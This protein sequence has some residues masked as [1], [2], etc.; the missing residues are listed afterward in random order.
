MTFRPTRVVNKERADLRDN[1]V[2]LAMFGGP[3]LN[4]FGPPET[5]P[6]VL[7][8]YGNMVVAADQVFLARIKRPV[9]GVD[10]PVK[11]IITGVGTGAAATTGGFGIYE[12][13]Y[14]QDNKARLYLLTSSTVHVAAGSIPQPSSLPEAYMLKR[15]KEYVLGIL[16]TASTY[17]GSVYHAADPLLVAGFGTSA[18]YVAASDFPPVINL[19]PLDYTGG[20][21]RV[22]AEP[23]GRTIMGYLIAPGKSPVLIY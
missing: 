9:R 5:V 2:E 8:T 15:N 21:P 10:Y 12:I 23:D 13:R 7:C 19:T 20:Y 6:D 11:A 18:S 17:A 4:T 3:D 22:Q 14:D 16:V 1:A